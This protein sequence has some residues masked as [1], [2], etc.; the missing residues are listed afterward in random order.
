MRMMTIII[1][2]TMKNKF[3]IINLRKHYD[4]NNNNNNDDDDVNDNNHNNSNNDED[5]EIDN[6]N[7]I[8]KAFSTIIIV[9]SRP[10]HSKCPST[11]MTNR[12]E[13]SP[14]RFMHLIFEG[15][16]LHPP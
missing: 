16:G 2:A 9:A 14:H 6:K 15:L 10:L 11:I 12:A 5:N 1:A 7:A 3:E 13:P 4:N 8:E